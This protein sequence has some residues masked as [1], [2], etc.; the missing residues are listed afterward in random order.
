MTNNKEDIDEQLDDKSGSDFQE[1]NYH[2][3]QIHASQIDNEFN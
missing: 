2:Y 1:I 3:D